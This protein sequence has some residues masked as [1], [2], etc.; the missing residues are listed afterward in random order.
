L[1]FFQQN[2]KGFYGCSD[3]SAFGGTREGLWVL[4]IPTRL[5]QNGLK[6]GGKVFELLSIF[7]HVA[8]FDLKSLS[9]MLEFI[10]LNFPT[11]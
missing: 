9:L 5:Q 10:K 1:I 11:G 8:H 7:F 6:W 4:F 3:I 2:K